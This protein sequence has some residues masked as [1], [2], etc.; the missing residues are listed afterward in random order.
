MTNKQLTALCWAIESLR[1]A[2]VGTTPGL[3]PQSAKDL[4]ALSDER[5]RKVAELLDSLNAEDLDN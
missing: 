5:S 1:S 3:T 2:I 4:A